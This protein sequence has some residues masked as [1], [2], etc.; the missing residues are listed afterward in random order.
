MRSWLSG[1]LKNLF[2]DSIA[3]ALGGAGLAMVSSAILIP[4]VTTLLDQAAAMWG[5]IPGDML[6]VIGIY[7]FGEAMSIIGSAM[8]TRVMIDATSVGIKRA[9]N[10]S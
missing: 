4:L 7:G 5:G 10:A 9:S 8:L 3:R 1:L 2:G 6:A